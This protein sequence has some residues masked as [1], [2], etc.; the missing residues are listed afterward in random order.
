V[1]KL[2]RVGLIGCGG[3][4]PA[5]LKVYKGLNDVELVA[6]CDLDKGRLNNLASQFGVKNLYQNYWDMFKAQNLDLVDIC[7]PVSTHRKIV[8]DSAEVVP[9]ILVEKPMALTLSDCDAMI[10]KV[11]KQGSKLCIGHNQLFAPNV[12]KAK[13]MVASGD[14]KVSSFKTTQKESF[15]L[16]LKHDLAPQWNVEPAQRGIIW[17]VCAHLAYLQLYFLPDVKEIYAVGGKVK[18]QVYDDFAVL[19]RTD[20]HRFGM[21]ELSWIDRET[22]IVWELSDPT[23]R[24]LQLIR[25]YDFMLD[26]SRPPPFT[27]PEVAKNMLVEEKRLMQKWA[28][29]ANSYFRKRKVLPTFNLITRYLEAIKKDLPPPVTPEEGRNTINLLESIEM[30]LNEKKPVRL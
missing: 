20:D 26:A 14:F 3:I 10:E 1:N 29:Y 13:S 23:G 22:E 12:L 25:D 8:C 24:R 18:Y 19:L 17:E 11:R 5:H 4:A 21:I 9:S 28:R 16:L 15:E 6:L 30:S 27:V 7:T 2:V